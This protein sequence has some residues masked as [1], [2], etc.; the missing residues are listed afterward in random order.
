MKFVIVYCT[1]DGKEHVTDAPVFG[2][3]DAAVAFAD[4][5]NGQRHS[6]NPGFFAVN[7]VAA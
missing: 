6:Q 5:R 4:R 3:R 7:E 1:A 2:T